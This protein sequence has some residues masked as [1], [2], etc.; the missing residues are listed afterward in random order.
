MNPRPRILFFG[1]AVTLAHV[2][3]VLVLGDALR[4]DHDVSLALAAHS[5][6]FVPPGV[7]DLH[8][9]DSI[10]SAQFVEALR[11][12]QPL[13]DEA[14]LG[15]YVEQD[16]ALIDAVQPDVVIGDFRISLSIS[17]RLRGVPY[18]TVANAYWSPWYSRPAP[19]PVLPWTRYV[20]LALAQT[21]FALARGPA[22]AA[23][24]MPMNRVRARF[25]LPSL[26]RDLKR[27]YTDADHVA[28]ADLPELFPTPDAP[29]T[30]TYLG[31]IL[32]SPTVAPPAWWR[33][34]FTGKS[35]YVTMGSSGDSSLLAGIVAALDDLG[36]T[37]LVA[38]AGAGFE[39][40]SGS[41][42]RV[43]PYL[44]GIEA[45]QR[46]DMVIC[47]G[48]S[49]TSQ[50]AL[51]AGKPVL[52]IASNMDQFFNMRAVTEAGA[53]LTVRADRASAKSIRSA[54]STL[55][56]S[57][58]AVTAA[59]RLSGVCARYSAPDAIRQIVA[60]ILKA[61]TTGGVRHEKNSTEPD[62]GVRAAVQPGMPAGM[63]NEPPR[64]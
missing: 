52:G 1:E 50:Q 13:Y 30:H 43:A 6:R 53:G 57:T 62:F 23:H 19:L 41:R 46:A 10:A 21:A 28:F 34:E 64:A 36:V 2:A 59:Q 20:P 25:G 51:A 61:G 45:A 39:P 33:E 9:L 27:V 15:R 14:T 54:A 24:A 8:S 5:H 11:R 29:S 16:L 26:G 44:P 7:F 37:A 58:A 60:G 63:G 40:A 56:D 48:G 31:P 38:T 49:L 4:R 18:V 22:M 17:A 32:W 55:L 12:G 47:N 3:R 42:A 35:A